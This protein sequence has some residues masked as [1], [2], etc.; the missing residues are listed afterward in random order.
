MESRE[1]SRTQTL[2]HRLSLH[3]I[4]GCREYASMIEQIAPIMFGTK[5]NL[6]KSFAE[7]SLLA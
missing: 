6:G 5:G 7:D 4:R 1:F 3:A 2:K